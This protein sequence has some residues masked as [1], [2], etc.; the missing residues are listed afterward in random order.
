MTYKDIYLAI[1]FLFLIYLIAFV[2]RPYVTTANT[3]RFFIWALTFK[4]IG[5]I[6]LGLIFQFYYGYG[7]DTMMYYEQGITVV[8][9]AFYH[10][11]VDGI[12]LIFTD[13][14]FHSSL[15]EYIPKIY[16]YY[17]SATYFIVRIGST[18]AILTGNTYTNTALCF[19]L[20][21]FSG[22]WALYSLI[23]KSIP[24]LS[25]QLAVAF[26][27]FP[28][29]FFW[30]S[31]LLKDAITMGSLC[32]MS[33][34]LISVLVYRERVLFNSLY[35]LFGFFIIKIKIYI[36]LCFLPAALVWVLTQYS[37]RLQNKWLRRFVTPVVL[38]VGIVIGAFAAVKLGESSPRYS[39]DKVFIT[40]EET[41][42]WL[43]Y[44]GNHDGGS[45]YSLGDFDYSPSGIAKKA[46]P[47]MWVTL[48]RPYV[49]EAKN[50]VMLLSALES[51]VFLLI[52]VYILLRHGVLSVVKIIMQQPFIAFCIIFSLMFSFAVGISTYN[53]GTLVRY[54][55][56]M[57]PFYMMGVFCV[58]YYLCIK[59]NR[60]P[61]FSK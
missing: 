3:R 7:G 2:V 61:V 38:G 27:F 44:M 1:P 20:F 25:R 58:D 13:N 18:F 21:S 24:D 15:A 9:E 26:F 14:E 33:Y 54:K 19:A 51:M 55:I 5:A 6:A 16:S 53:F 41:A 8:A 47:A 34:G 46:I 50:I 17:D 48:F 42:R 52:T 49:F 32:W 60:K 43:T 30:G 37:Q 12:Q 29:L 35:F 28:S 57:M 36:M 45:V 11:P 22:L 59:K 39:I 10:N 31:G 40:A 56:P 23:C 4:L